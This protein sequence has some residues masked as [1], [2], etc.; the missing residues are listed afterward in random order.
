MLITRRSRW[1]SGTEHAI[2]TALLSTGSTAGIQCALM[3]QAKTDVHEVF[4]CSVCQ[5]PIVR[6]IDR[7]FHWP[8]DWQTNRWTDWQ[9]ERPTDWQ[10]NWLTGLPTEWQTYRPID[11]LKDRPIDRPT[12]PLTDI[13]AVRL[14]YWPTDQLSNWIAWLLEHLY[15]FQPL[16]PAC[17]ARFPI[18]TA[19]K[20]LAGGQAR[21]TAINNFLD[22]V[23]TECAE[24]RSRALNGWDVGGWHKRTMALI[25]TVISFFRLYSASAWRTRYELMTRQYYAVWSGQRLQKIIP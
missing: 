1:L 23:I 3:V 10:T 7:P 8:T 17:T 11:R 24:Q 25:A 9:T 13:Q 5:W 19:R 21:A 12:N 22:N 14:V 18:Y 16:Y 4:N 20:L 6:P 2:K 15:S